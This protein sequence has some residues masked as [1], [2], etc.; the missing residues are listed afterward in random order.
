MSSHTPKTPFLEKSLPVEVSGHFLL[1][2]PDNEGPWPVLCGFHGYGETAREQL[3]RLQGIEGAEN[4]LICSLQALHPFYL[5]RHKE[6]GASWITREHRDTMIGE[7]LAYVE[8]VLD[9]LDRHYAI[10]DTVVY[11]GF[12][13]GA[14][15]ACRAAAHRPEDC[16]GLIIHGNALPEELETDNLAPLPPLFLSRTDR[17]Q[18]YP[19]S[20]FEK[21]L[22][23]CQK[24][25]LD[26]TPFTCEGT[27]GWPE[28]LNEPLAN[29]LN[30]IWEKEL[31]RIP[32]DG[33]AGD[34]HEWSK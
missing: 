13:Q 23:C 30:A 14:A 20:A 31:L 21:D 29:F 33:L 7:N 5:P 26:L 16:S 19:E 24:A 9:W 8:S 27:H 11:A 4:W 22:K 15:M 6:V 32:D 17:D 12:S 2:L 28:A 1:A 10:A 25:G 34:H 3:D 18:V